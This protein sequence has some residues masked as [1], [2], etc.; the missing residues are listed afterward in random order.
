MNATPPLEP[1]VSLLE[2]PD[3][4]ALH[5]LV[6]DQ[7]V[8]G[9]TLWVDAGGA[10]STYGL[11]AQAQT[12]RALRGI[13]VARAFTAHQHH[14]LV[15]HCVSTA[16]GRTGLVVAPN[17]TALYDAA[18]A[19]DAEIDPLF[20]AS[21]ALLADLADALAIPV[22]LSAP[23]AREDRFAA[24]EDIVDHDIECAST[25]LGYAYSTAT[26]ETQGYW[27]EGW[28]QTTLPYWAD[29]CG[30]RA[31]TDAWANA[32][33]SATAAAIER[34]AIDPT[35]STPATTQSPIAADGGW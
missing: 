4:G 34:G 14:Q 24:V 7:D 11:T 23:R 10:A 5:R 31:W 20:S 21:L 12:R 17:V 3:V 9:E 25:G 26:F 19:G 16:S 30:T 22:L 13:R 32:R 35:E 29:L 6:L 15:R 28:W 18:D 33:T 1:G 8:E 2:Q 27:H